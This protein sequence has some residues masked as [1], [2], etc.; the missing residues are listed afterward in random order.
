MRVIDADEL[1]VQIHNRCDVCNDKDT[2]WCEHCCSVNDWE[3]YID[4]AP[5]VEERPKGKWMFVHPLQANDDGAYMCSYCKTGSFGIENT[6]NFCP[7]CG[8]DMRGDV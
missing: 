6:Y 4:N 2:A 3:D 7:Y 5:T 1:K 8:A